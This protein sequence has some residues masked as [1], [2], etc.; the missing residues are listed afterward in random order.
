MSPD[1]GPDALSG[2]EHAGENDA[3]GQRSGDEHVDSGTGASSPGSPAYD[4][5][6]QVNVMGGE[7]ELDLAERRRAVRADPSAD[8]AAAA[9]SRREA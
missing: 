1:D 8:P 7:A 9:P 3:D 5:E 4:G 2:G 6:V